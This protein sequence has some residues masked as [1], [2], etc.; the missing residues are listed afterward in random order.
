MQAECEFDQ[1]LSKKRKF[2]ETSAASS[3]DVDAFDFESH[4]LYCS[5]AHIKTKRVK[6]LEFFKLHIYDLQGQIMYLKRCQTS[7]LPWEDIALALKDDT[8]K[9]VRD[10]RSLKQEVDEYARMSDLLK[11]WISSMV[12]PSRCLFEES[13]RHARLF[14]GDEATRKVGLAW[15]IRQMYQNTERALSHLVYPEDGDF[16]DIQVIETDPNVLE[17]RVMHQFTVDATFEAVS[18]AMYTAE[19]SFAKYYLKR[20]ADAVRLSNAGCDIEYYQE[21]V[22]PAEQNITDYFILG[23]FHDEDQTTLCLKTILDDAYP[24]EDNTW[25]ALTKQWVI[26]TRQGANKTRLRSY[27][28]IEHPSCQNGFVPLEQVAN[29]WGIKGEDSSPLTSRLKERNVKSHTRQRQ[30]YVEHFKNVLDFATT[31]VKEE[32]V[33][34]TKSL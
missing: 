23:R 12:T 26:A 24:L 14:G 25:T 18:E 20:D 16:L 5:L 29:L 19:K 30:V 1:H 9:K 27:Y 28:S 8:L 6:E 31:S 15:I 22:G 11:A 32:Q 17:T 4:P 3:E 10:N 34:R 33:E 21:Q 7:K 13:W 2:Y